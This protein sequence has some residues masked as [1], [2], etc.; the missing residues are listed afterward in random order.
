[1]FEDFF[2]QKFCDNYLEIIKNRLYNDKG[3]KRKSAQYALYHAYLNILKMVA[4]FVPHI[5]EE[6]YHGQDNYF[7]KNENRKSIHLTSWPQNEATINKEVKKGVEIM[8]NIISEVRKYKS[9]KKTR[10]DESI[11]LLAITCSKEKQAI[12]SPFVDDLRGVS[13]AEKVVITQQELGSDA[14][15][16]N[17][18]V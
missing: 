17:I 13:R 5:A 3:I 11:S 14:S 9:I 16:L 4:P 12:L 7:S 1:M 18:I 6:M 10:L 2:W 8:L 15:A